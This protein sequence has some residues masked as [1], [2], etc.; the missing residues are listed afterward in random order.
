MPTISYSLSINT[1][2][3]SPDVYL[4]PMIIDSDFKDESYEIDSELSGNGLISKPEVS[5]TGSYI[6]TSNYK[7]IVDGE[8]VDLESE[9]IVSIAETNLQVMSTNEKG[10]N[11]HRLSS[12]SY[13]YGEATL[14]ATL[15][16][17]GGRLSIK[18]RFSYVQGTPELSNTYTEYYIGENCY[19]V[20]S[21]EDPINYIS[22]RKWTYQEYISI[23]SNPIG[24]TAADLMAIDG[25][26]HMEKL[27]LQKLL[28][29]NVQLNY[30]PIFDAALILIEEDIT[31][32]KHWLQILDGEIF[33]LE[34]QALGLISVD[35]ARLSL[36]MG[37]AT[38]KNAYAFYGVVPIVI[39]NT[40][41]RK[42]DLSAL[43]SSFSGK[44]RFGELSHKKLKEI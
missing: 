21:Q 12:D 18:D 14:V 6:E 37:A 24:P 44:I 7:Y 27:D 10:V 26:R 29:G 36:H 25:V 38:I 41:N 28:D 13:G 33:S 19:I 20:T 2:S 9:G 16:N 23:F 42:I 17:K 5:I 8:I 35:L 1:L 4:D 43:T 31:G 15:R 22:N 11:K 39:H 40:E 32:I 30:F 34:D 3:I